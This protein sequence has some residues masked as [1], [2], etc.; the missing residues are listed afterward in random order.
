MAFG[1]ACA[2]GEF[3]GGEVR[4]DDFCVC[5]GGVVGALLGDDQVA[6]LAE[7]GFCWAG[8]CAVVG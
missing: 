2:V 8:C 4:E 3:V 7:D 6:E 5:E 1:G